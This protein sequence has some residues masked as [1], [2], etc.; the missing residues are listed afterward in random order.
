MITKLRINI[1]KYLFK[2]IYIFLVREIFFIERKTFFM[3]VKYFYLYVK[4]FLP[5]KTRKISVFFLNHGNE[6]KK[7]NR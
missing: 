5:E 4:Y 1:I 3:R 2:I 7:R 6:S